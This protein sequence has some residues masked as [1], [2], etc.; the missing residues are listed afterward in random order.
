[1]TEPI[2]GPPKAETNGAAAAAEE[3]E[4][5]W[6]LVIGAVF[7]AIGVLLCALWLGPMVAVAAALVAAAVA[8][9]RRAYVGAAAFAAGAALASLAARA[10]LPSTFALF[11]SALAFGVGLAIAT[12]E[13]MQGR[14]RALLG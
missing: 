3:A 1:M 2:V 8:V 11:L 5:L 12:R 7:G 14:V 9:M 10:L 4:P 6:A 13:R